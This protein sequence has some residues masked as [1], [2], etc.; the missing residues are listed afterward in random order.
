MSSR[1]THIL[2]FY[3]E[4]LLYDAE[5]LLEAIDDIVGTCGLKLLTRGIAVADTYAT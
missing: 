3:A 2:F 4:I 5:E 1:A